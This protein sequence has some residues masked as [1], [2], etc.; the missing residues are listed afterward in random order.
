MLDRLRRAINAVLSRTVDRYIE[1]RIRRGWVVFGDSRRVHLHPSVQ[2]YGAY[3]NTTSG[4][5]WVEEN[6]FFGHH[7]K[8]LTGTHDVYAFDAERRAA[9]P[10]T[11]RDIVVRHGAWISAGSIVL[12]PCTIGENAVVAAGAV[13]TKDVPPYTLVAGVPAAPIRDLRSAPT[14]NA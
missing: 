14:T 13:V 12:G 3:F 10:H 6:V 5:I 7:A 1:R 11:G 2:P 8:L 9:I 4:E